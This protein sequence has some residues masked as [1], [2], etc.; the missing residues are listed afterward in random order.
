MPWNPNTDVPNPPFLLPC[1][2]CGKHCMETEQVIDGFHEPSRGK[3]IRI[4]A[5]CDEVSAHAN[6]KD[7]ERT[8]YAPEAEAVIEWNRDFGKH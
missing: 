3:L 4:N 7:D 8:S 2:F 1:K 6:E 5:M